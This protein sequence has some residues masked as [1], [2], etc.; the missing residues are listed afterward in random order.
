MEPGER[1][2]GH[3]G[4]AGEGGSEIVLVDDD[5]DDARRQD[6]GTEFAELERRQRRGRGRLGHDRV[7]GEKGQR[8]LIISRSTGSSTA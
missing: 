2:L 5:V 6:P 7:A 4:V 8:D 3:V 1:D